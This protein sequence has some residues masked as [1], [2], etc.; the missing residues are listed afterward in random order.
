MVAQHLGRLCLDDDMGGNGSRCARA[1]AGTDQLLGPA[2][3]GGQRDPTTS[4]A[5]EWRA[6]PPNEVTRLVLQSHRRLNA[7]KLLHPRL[8]DGAIWLEAE[9][10]ERIVRLI[11]PKCMVVRVPADCRTI[12]AAL[13]AAMPG[14]TVRVAPGVYREQLV[15][16]PSPSGITVMG[17]GARPGD[18]V[19]E[20][21][22]QDA[23]DAGVRMHIAGSPVSFGKHLG[24]G[25]GIGACADAVA[26][27]AQIAESILCGGILP[28][29][30]CVC[31][32]GS[33]GL[34]CD[35]ARPPPHAHT[36]RVEAAYAL[37]EGGSSHWGLGLAEDDGHADGHSDPADD[38]S[39]GATTR[40]A[41]AFAAT[42][43]NMGRLR[44][45]LERLAGSEAAHSWTLW[46]RYCA[47]ARTHASGARL[48]NLTLRARGAGHR[49]PYHAG[50][51][52][53]APRGMVWCAEAACFLGCCSSHTDRLW[54]TE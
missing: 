17:D 6:K 47:V 30:V 23:L 50:A 19:V 48:A 31:S 46:R 28:R 42:T 13:R 1:A 3:Y 11:P 15:M 7:S 16:Q 29:G 45:A 14:D 22:E 34:G 20:W 2:H 40:A 44:V 37:R 4:S 27:D 8:G 18:V 39:S 12:G 53:L 33:A 49:T 51:R 52:A 32:R 36:R 10:I 35:S 38:S 21:G 43:G 26:K 9:L 41:A 25:A 5:A 54:L 24:G